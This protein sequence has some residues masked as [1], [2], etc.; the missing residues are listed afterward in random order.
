MESWLPWLGDDRLI[1]DLLP[2]TAKVVL[3]EPRRMRDRASELLAEEDDLAKALASTWARDPN[4]RFPR[5]HAEPDRLLADIASFW[6][7]SSAPESPETPVV[8]ASGWGPL[9]GDG[10]A[11]ANRLG[12]LIADRYRVVVAADGAGSAERL[13]ALLADHGWASRSIPTT[14]SRTSPYPVDTSWS[15]HSTVASRCPR[16]VWR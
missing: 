2:D 15:P 6:S 12:E 9:A 1:T 13:A 5:L 14:P 10:A 7:I 3:V 4:R 11:L 16:P 8:D